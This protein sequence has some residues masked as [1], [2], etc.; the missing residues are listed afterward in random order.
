MDNKLDV[1][2]QQALRNG[3]A[4]RPRLGIVAAGIGLG[5]VLAYLLSKVLGSAE[6]EPEFF[7]EHIVDDKG[8]GQQ[9]AAKILLNLR[10]RG[11]EASDEK[12]SLALGRPVEEVTGWTTGREL[13]D[14]DVVM[15][16]RGIAMHRG[17]H[18]E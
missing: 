15:K 10:N 12:L 6:R 5:S 17:I 4:R 2:N 7:S 18:V 8:T 9:Q 16:A 14:D 3:K 1:Q 11:F 13:I